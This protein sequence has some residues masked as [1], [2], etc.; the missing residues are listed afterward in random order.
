MIFLHNYQSR[1][2]CSMAVSNMAVIIE[3]YV[4]SIYYCCCAVVN[5]KI[6]YPNQ[7]GHKDQISHLPTI[8]SEHSAKDS[9]IV[10]AFLFQ[11]MEHISDHYN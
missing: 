5:V 9:R 11:G 6:D 10:L 4:F 1:P 8:G 7:G 3:L 2:K